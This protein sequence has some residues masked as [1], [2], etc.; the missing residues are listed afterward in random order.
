MGLQYIKCSL[1]HHQYN[2]V[3]ERFVRTR[4]ILK[5]E[6][7]FAGITFVIDGTPCQILAVIH[8]DGGLRIVQGVRNIHIFVY[9]CVCLSVCVSV[10]PSVQVTT[11]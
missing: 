8:Y 11:S 9:V 10:C 2:G 1:Y 4:D 3:V 6:K 7:P 5:V